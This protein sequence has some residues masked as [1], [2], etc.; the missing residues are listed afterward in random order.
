MLTPSELIQANEDLL[1]SHNEQIY[2]I[3]EELFER[4]NIIQ[5]SINFNGDFFGAV[6]LAMAIQRLSGDTAQAL[7]KLREYTD[8]LYPGWIA[9]RQTSERLV[10]Q[11]SED[12][13]KVGLSE[14]HGLIV[15]AVL[16]KDWEL[17]LK[18]IHYARTS[19]AVVSLRFD[20]ELFYHFTQALMELVSPQSSMDELVFLNMKKKLPDSFIGYPELFRAV[21]QRHQSHFDQ[22][23]Q[24]VI[25]RFAKRAK[26]RADAPM[27]FGYGKHDHRECFD[28]RAT[29]A[30]ICAVKAGM[31]LSLE[32][33]YVPKTLVL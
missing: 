7:K 22:E 31:Q 13:Y 18:E 15:C 30:A 29:F 1:A 2:R 6:C 12:A 17:A 11:E 26:S 23:L 14:F 27:G 20:G 3:N 25:E 5:A 19:P 32:S 4:K 10:S 28:Y 16:L 24:N 33:E 9:I 8:K 21:L